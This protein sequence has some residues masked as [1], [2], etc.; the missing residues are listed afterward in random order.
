MNIHINEEEFNYLKQNTLLKIVVGSHLYQLNND[1]SDKDI[2]YITNNLEQNLH[3]VVQLHHQYQYK[4]NNTD[5]LICSLQNFIKNLISGDSTINF[6]AL[7]SEEIKNHKELSF[8]YN[9][10]KIM[11]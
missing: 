2:L 1:Q 11:L 4:N 9:F 3:S 7:F 10:R 5:Y 6:E 8:L